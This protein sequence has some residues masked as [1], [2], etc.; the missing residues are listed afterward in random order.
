MNLTYAVNYM[1]SLYS[2][3][4]GLW[5]WWLWKNIERAH[6]FSAGHCIWPHW[7]M[8]WYV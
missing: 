5:D 3:D 2:V 4:M 1:I 6:W 8:A 7:K